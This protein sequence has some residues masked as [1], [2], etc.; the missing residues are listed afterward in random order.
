MSFTREVVQLG[1][2]SVDGEGINLDVET[3]CTL[4]ENLDHR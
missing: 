1:N 2:A 4:R 3:A